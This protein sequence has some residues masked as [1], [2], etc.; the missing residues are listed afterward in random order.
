[1]LILLLLMSIYDIFNKREVPDFI[2][3]IYWLIGLF[4]YP[5]LQYIILTVLFY[6]LYLIKKP[7]GDAEIFIFPSIFL[8][9]NLLDIL[10][11]LIY[12]GL[13]I[14]S[15][16]ISLISFPIIFFNPILAMIVA[17][18]L[19]IFGRKIIPFIPAIFLSLIF[20]NYIKLQPLSKLLYPLYFYLS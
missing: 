12:F 15:F 20:V 19:S 13:I 8:Q 4:F 18:I 9:P 3:Y 1:M 5:Q 16:P 6:I 7:Y 2:V 14:A 17:I 10:F 11:F